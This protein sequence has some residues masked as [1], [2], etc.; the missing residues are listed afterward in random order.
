MLMVLLM[1]SGIVIF[2]FIL[3]SF[4]IP[5]SWRVKEDA[6]INLSLEELYE[7]LLHV[8]NWPQWQMDDDSELAFMYVGPE[9]GEGAS[10]YWETG[11][12]PACLK[13]VRCEYN[14][15]ISYQ[16]RIN[17]GETIL[18]FTLDFTN[19]HASVKLIWMCEGV[20]KRNPFERYM[21]LFYRWK[22]KQNMKVS[23]TR[24]QD[25]YGLQLKEMKQSA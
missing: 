6:T 21:T 9:K 17:K 4:I 1:I 19:D 20:S 3:F 22:M 11:G 23:L 2:L 13:I 8:K 25:I 14:K 5:N 15:R 10:Q 18:K 16:M 7:S 12:V 24:L